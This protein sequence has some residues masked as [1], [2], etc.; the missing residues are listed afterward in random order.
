MASNKFR[1]GF[2]PVQR[3]VSVWFGA[4]FLGLGMGAT[5]CSEPPRLKLTLSQREMADTLYLER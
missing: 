4:V 1:L 5:S 2:S 3:G